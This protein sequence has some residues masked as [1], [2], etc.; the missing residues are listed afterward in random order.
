MNVDLCPDENNMPEN[1]VLVRFKNR[2]G[3]DRIATVETTDTIAARN[4]IDWL[5]QDCEIQ[6]AQLIQPP[7]QPS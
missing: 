3:K 1:H 5:F 7:T 2:V 6:T 4:A